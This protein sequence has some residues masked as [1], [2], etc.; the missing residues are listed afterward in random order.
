[1]QLDT[2]RRSARTARTGSRSAASAARRRREQLKVCVNELGGF[3][4]T[5][6]LVLTGLDVDA[7]ADWVR[8]QLTASLGDRAPA[9]V[10]WSRTSQPPLD[11]ET[12]EAAS[13]L[14]RCTVQDPSA[15][16][17]GRTFTAAA[18]ELA[19]ASYPGFTMTAPPGARHA[20]RRLPARRTSTARP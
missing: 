13:V 4:N 9:T 19:L 7:K 1:M 17:V 10:T 12:E 20:V 16:P 15:D 6:E 14:L 11:A 18:V 2:D 5:V 3:R 8:E